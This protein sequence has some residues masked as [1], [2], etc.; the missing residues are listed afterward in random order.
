[1]CKTN[2]KYFHYKEIKKKHRNFTD[3]FKIALK[4]LH[5]EKSIQFG[6]KVLS[7]YN[8]NSNRIKSIL[9]HGEN[10]ISKTTMQ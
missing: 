1:M 9:V 7:R 6:F 8:H 4:K 2:W 3:V 10:S 5:S